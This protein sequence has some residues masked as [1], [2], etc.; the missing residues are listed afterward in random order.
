MGSYAD[1]EH[2]FNYVLDRDQ[3]NVT[4]RTYLGML[5]LLMGNYQEGWILYK[6]RWKM[7]TWPTKM[8]FPEEYLWDGTV[9]EGINGCLGRKKEEDGG[10]LLKRYK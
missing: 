6:S 4:A 3:N 10:K 8:V 1:A 2:E 9:K 7:S 5:K